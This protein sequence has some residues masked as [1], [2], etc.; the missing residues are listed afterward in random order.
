MD[1]RSR[2]LR[3]ADRAIAVLTAAIPLGA[4][5]AFGGAVWWFKPALAAAT[6]L[7]ALAWIVRVAVLGEIRALRSPLT[8]LGAA[9]VILAAIQI[10]PLPAGLVRRLSPASPAVTMAEENVD[11]SGRMTLSVDRSSTLRRLAGLA[12]ALFFFHVVSHF[13]DRLERTKL[14]WGALIAGLFVCTAVGWVQVL[15]ATDGLY[16]FLKPGD[17]TTW[18]PSTA[19]LAAVPNVTVLREAEGPGSSA[20]AGW[21]ISRPDR[22]DALAGLMGGPGAYCALAA[23]GLPLALGLIL[24]C[25]APRGSREPLRLRLAQ[26]GRSGRVVTAVAML[27]LTS[28]L[29]GRFVGPIGSVPIAVGLLI[30]GVPSA[31]R[32]GLGRSAPLLT[33]LTL[34]ALVGGIAA[35]H[36]LSTPKGSAAISQGAGVAVARAVWAE[37]AR[38]AVDHPIFGVGMGGFARLH[39]Y[40]KA[41]DESR[42]TAE[43]SLLQW[44]VESGAVGAI[45]LLAGVAWCLAHLP[46]A[47]R[48]VG[49]ADRALGFALMGAMAAFGGFSLLHWTVELPAVALA[50]CGVGGTCNRWLSGGTDLFVE[51]S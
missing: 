18:A 19:D 30:T 2:C 43:S 45:L 10:T 26:S 15:G 49:S 29:V 46:R 4:I 40:Y 44:V 3:A 47:L 12:S 20:K 6:F 14:A 17:G 8:A 16:G 9:A 36:S 7:L 51:R 42:T 1:A 27:L 35:G 28:G 34:F 50:A 23:L 38:I 37:S 21:I 32:T 11:S 5:L 13:V 25:L 31:F 33:C 48:T 39:P 41:T 24:Q 22:P